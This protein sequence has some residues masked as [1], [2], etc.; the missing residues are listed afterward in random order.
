L[1]HFAMDFTRCHRLTAESKLHPTT[2]PENLTQ[3]SG[4]KIHKT[5]LLE[6]PGTRLS[7]AAQRQSD[8][9]PSSVERVVL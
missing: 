5:E 8:A 9:R 6:K 7:S 2:M 4:E 1:V 3:N